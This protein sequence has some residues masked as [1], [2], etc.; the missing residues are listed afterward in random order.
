ME[1]QSTG[2]RVMW[3]CLRWEADISHTCLG[4]FSGTS[5]FLPQALWTDLS[6][7]CNECPALQIR[8]TLQRLRSQRFRAGCS[9]GGGPQAWGL[10]ALERKGLGNVEDLGVGL[11]SRPAS[12]CC[13]A[14][15]SPSTSI[16]AICPP[17][18]APP[19]PPPPSSSAHPDSQLPSFLSGLLA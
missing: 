14:R 13:E 2:L 7:I 15:A 17:P 4:V 6:P 9:D 8:V 16:G 19:L 12:A 11:S 18:S 1:V 10:K 5:V 3:G